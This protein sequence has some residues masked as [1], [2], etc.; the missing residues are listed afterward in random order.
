M[1]YLRGKHHFSGRYFFAN[2]SEPARPLGNDILAL[3]SNANR[4]RVQTMSLNE[5]YTASPTLLFNTWFGWNQQNGGYI[6]SAPFSANALG[7]NIAPSPSP[8]FHVS[9][10]GYFTAMSTNVGAY[11]RGDT[12]LREVVT[13]VRGKHQITFGGEM[14]QVRA[15]IAKQYQQAGIFSFTDSL[16]GDNLADLMLGAV[17]QFVQ[18][19]GIYGNIMGTKWSAFT[20][21]DWRVTPRLALSGG[22]RWDPYFPYTDSEGR[23]PCFEPGKRSQRYPN[24]PLGLLFANDPGCP[25][26]SVYSNLSNFAPRIGFAYRLTSDGR[27]S[28]RGGAGYYYQPPETLAFQDDVGA[29]PFT[30]IY[31]LNVVNFADPFGSAGIPNPFPADFGPKLPPPSTTFTLPTTVG[32]F[33]RLGFRLPEI[34]MWN[35]TLERQVA[36]TWLITVAYVGNR[37][38]HLYGTSDQEPM[39]DLNAARYVPNNSTEANTQQR[40]PYINFGPMGS[41][42]SGFNFSYHAV[43]LSLQKYLSH[44]LSFLANYTWSRTFSDFSESV[45]ESYYQTDPFSR[46]FNYGPSESDIPYVFKAW[47]TWQIP[48]FRLSGVGDR[49]LNGWELASIMLWQSGLPYSIMSGFDDSF[50]GDFSDRADFIGAK[51]SQ[52]R[53]SP[54][55]PHAQQIREYF[56]TALFKPNA[57]GTFGDSGK[58]ILRGPGV[59][60]VDFALLKNTKI[61]ER[62]TLQFRAEVYDAFNNVNFNQP[63]SATTDPTFGQILS[64]AVGASPRVMQFA[65]KLLF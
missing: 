22:L 57:V 5:N 13:A 30:P 58:N 56:N 2:F 55:R 18:A 44:G 61:H 32:H 39:A 27:T 65:L 3:D 33:F 19:G 11:N 6:P 50:S 59:F 17:T 14:L 48:H 7:V 9:V 8:Q 43:E 42:D 49:L 10:G 28:F 37:G 16:S 46:S 26:G 29:A 52:A 25:A 34:T 38:T 12:T 21:D 51:I 1:D 41:I 45:T 31:T 20:Q 15:R 64:T 62:Y 36:R 40:R 63:D 24:A 35:L 47:G 54:G 60:N 23:L 53:L 4:V